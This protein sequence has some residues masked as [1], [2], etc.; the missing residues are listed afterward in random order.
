MCNLRHERQ[1][2]EISSILIGIRRIHISVLIYCYNV[3]LT[4]NN[5]GFRRAEKFY[6]STRNQILVSQIPFKSQAINATVHRDIQ[7]SSGKP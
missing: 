1:S 3:H 2:I 7:P 5:S 4:C 6:V